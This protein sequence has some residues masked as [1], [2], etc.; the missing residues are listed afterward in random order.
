[1]TLANSHGVSF[2]I[3][4]LRVINNTDDQISR[5]ETLRY[6]FLA[7]GAADTDDSVVSSAAEAKE[8][9]KQ[10][11]PWLD[12]IIKTGAS[13]PLYELVEEI[14]GLSAIGK[15]PG[16]AIFLST[17]QDTILTYPDRNKSNLA[18]FLEWWD[19]T[20]SFRSVILPEGAD[21]SRVFTIHKSKGLEFGIVII[22]F[23]SWNTEPKPA[24]YPIMWENPAVSP[25]NDIGLVPVKYGKELNETIFAESYQKEKFS[26]VLDNLNLLY[27]AMTRARDAIFGFTCSSPTH[28][29]GIS[30]LLTEALKSSGNESP[31]NW[32]SGKFDTNKNIFECG[33]LPVKK[34]EIIFK[35]GIA[36]NEY[37]V[38][39]KPESLR[40]KLHGEN[41]FTGAEDENRKKI[42][43]GRLM[44]ELFEKIVIADDLKSALN[45]MM[46]EGRI[47][48]E[49]KINLE[50]RFRDLI[51]TEKVSEWFDPGNIV[52]NEASILVPGG[53]IRRPDRVVIRNNTV[54]VIDFKFGEP[55]GS[56]INQVVKYK[57]LL[58]EMGHERVEGYVWYVDESKIVAA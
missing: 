15:F 38:S 19:S 32:L 52:L 51:K 43:Y 39:V 37:V 54:I 6:Y 33:S 29:N 18:H 35:P 21:A 42:R 48:P 23:L 24:H 14:I 8:A 4:V 20:G 3:S 5:A 49:E 17:L 47:G 40:L 9:L 25:F 28:L 13:M 50:T 56:H 34:S 41:Y 16:W 55:S 53:E 11:L 31:V 58:R 22:P 36:I 30:K 1:L 27:V 57:N 10:Y 7:T 26:S 44:H 12:S 46:L 2:V 45:T